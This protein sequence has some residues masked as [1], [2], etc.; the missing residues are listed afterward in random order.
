MASQIKYTFLVSAIKIVSNK[1]V[2]FSFEVD[3]EFSFINRDHL[4]EI[5]D[6]VG[7]EIFSIHWSLLEKV[8]GPYYGY[9]LINGIK[10][11]ECTLT[12]ITV[13]EN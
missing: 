8:R 10:I 13:F 9:Y 6:F 1:L 2:S 7:E 11:K 12:E 5:K 4:K 3:S